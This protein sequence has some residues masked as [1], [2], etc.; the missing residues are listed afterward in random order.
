MFITFEGLDGSGKTTHQKLLAKI[1]TDLGHDVVVT[2]EPGG[3]AL[4]QKIRD[5]IFDYGAIKEAELFL[6][7]AAR[8]QHVNDTIIPALSNN[9]IILCDRFTDSTIAYQGYAHG[10]PLDNL[11]DMCKF[12]AKGLMP[13]LTFLLDI[14]PEESLNRKSKCNDKNRLD[15]NDIEFYR[16]VR[17]GFI[18]EA[19]RDRFRFSIIDSSKEIEVT[20]KCIVDALKVCFV[21][22]NI[23]WKKA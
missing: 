8:A 7:L 13:N 11:R 16:K 6:M 3:S 4:G 9:K 10:M 17:K 5:I 2:R 14:E 12:S 19:C 23:K 1:L 15:S 20:S 21:Y 18:E 22:R